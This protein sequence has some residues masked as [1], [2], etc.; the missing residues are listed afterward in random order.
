MSE[1]SFFSPWKQSPVTMKNLLISLALCFTVISSV[2]SVK[3]TDCGTSVQNLDIQISSCGASDDYCPFV[4]GTNVTMNATF[5]V[6]S[7]VESAIIKLYGKLGPVQVPFNLKPDEACGNWGMVCPVSAGQATQ[8]VITL[9]IQS[10][11]K[12]M[13]VGVRL[14]LWS[15]KSKLI[16]RQFPAKLVK[17]SST[18][19]PRYQVRD[20]FAWAQ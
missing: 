17:S 14:E 9:P 18:W 20:C 15:G 11:Y 19:F 5:T 16:C 10:Y 13:N 12:P 4:I 3:F 7:Q 1:E 2:S 8:L 6:T